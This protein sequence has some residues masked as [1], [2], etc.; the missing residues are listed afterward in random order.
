MK[1]SGEGS[2]GF[3]DFS[4]SADDL[5][6]L[7]KRISLTS[8]DE[9]VNDI[10][11]TLQ[12]LSAWN[13]DDALKEIVKQLEEELPTSDLRKLQWGMGII[14]YHILGDKSRKPSGIVL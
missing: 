8:S 2:K 4:A 1:T 14:G 6:K 7:R 3:G 13:G 10:H 9:K 11:S 12:A 5:R